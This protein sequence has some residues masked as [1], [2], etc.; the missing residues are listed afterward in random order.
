MRGVTEP[1]MLRIAMISVHTC[2]LAELGSRE[3]G[4]MNVYVRELSRHLGDRGVAVDVFTRRQDPDV[5]QVVG[6]GE[7]A[8]VVHLDAGPAGS[9]DKY[10]V[11]EHLPQ[12]IQGMSDFRL[13]EGLDY[14]LIHSHY[15]LSS[16]VAI[17]FAQRWQL[18]LVTMFH[19]LGQLKNQVSRDGSER[20]GSE[21]IEIERETVR[22]ADRIVAASPPDM[23]HMV[24]YYGA[25][26]SKMT[27]VPGGVDTASFHHLPMD[28]ARTILDLGPGRLVLFVGRIQKLKG[29]DLLLR[30]FAQL[31]NGWTDGMKP[32]LMVVGGQ[33][34]ATP[35][36]LEAAELARLRALAHQLGV[37]DQVAFQ[38]AVEHSRLPV[39]YAAADVVVMPSMYES[40]GL[41]A[42]EAMACGTPVVASRVGGLRSTVQDGRTGFLVGGRTPEQFAAAIEPILRDPTLRAS[43]SAAAVEVAQSFSW[44]G[45]AD[46][47]LRLYGELVQAGC[48]CSA[49]TMCCK[50]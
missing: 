43:M 27:V 25:P 36:D 14:D 31:S 7:N 11:L 6:L 34:T 42:L 41:V 9:M 15:W 38:G 1:V 21:R 19:T 23:Q 47:T 32:R 40:F 10:D 18:P 12:F 35:G 33:N 46:R 30:A 44:A 4:G 3:T 2:P 50:G 22:I 39:Y 45:A 8:R 13:Q 29:I 28:V 17:H 49:S 26:A 48:G 24:E 5:P 16:P 20:E 37:L